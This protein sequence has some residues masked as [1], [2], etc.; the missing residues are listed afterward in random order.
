MSDSCLTCGGLIMEPGKVYGYAG[1]VCYCIK[2]PKICR[3]SQQNIQ[4]SPSLGHVHIAQQ[5]AAQKANEIEKLK[6]M[7]KE[8]IIEYVRNK[9]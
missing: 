3:P 2:E 7:S 1:P 9:R 6:G 4:Q 5:Y 8:E